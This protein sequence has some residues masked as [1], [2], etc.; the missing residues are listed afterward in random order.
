MRDDGVTMYLPL[1]SFAT[2]KPWG[3]KI[4]VWNAMKE[5]TLFK[6]TGITTDSPYNTSVSGMTKQSFAIWLLTVT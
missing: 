1:S 2:L 3:K 6:R 5:R 4:S